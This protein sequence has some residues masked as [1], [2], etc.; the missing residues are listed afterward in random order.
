LFYGAKI[1]STNQFY[2]IFVEQILFLGKIPPEQR[3][4][5]ERLLFL[6]DV[7]ETGQPG[8]EKKEIPLPG[9]WA[10]KGGKTL[11]YCFVAL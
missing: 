2:P 7:I 1:T 8:I 6:F 3:Q 5:N 4:A 9:N 11:L 10:T